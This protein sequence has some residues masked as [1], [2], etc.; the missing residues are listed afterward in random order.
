MITVREQVSPLNGA[1]VFGRRAFRA[2]IS[3]VERRDASD[4]AVLTVIGAILLLLPAIW[5]GHPFLFPDSEHYFSIGKSIV[6]SIAGKIAGALMAGGA[7]S[8]SGGEPVAAQAGSGGLA[9]I[10]GG[11]SPVYAVL[12]YGLAVRAGIWGIVILQSA[13]VSWLTVMVLNLV[14]G[15]RRAGAVVAALAGLALVTPAGAFSGFLMPDV[16]AAT[17]VLAAVLLVFDATA[18]RGRSLVYAS[19]IALSLVMHATII[20]LG[21][22]AFALVALCLPIPAARRLVR[23]ESLLWLAGALVLSIAFNAAYVR[24]A[25]RLS[26]H[27]IS[28]PPYLMAR[29]IAD[30]PGQK[31]LAATC[32]TPAAPFAACAFAHQSFVDHNDFLWGNAS[33]G[34]NFSASPQDLKTALIAEEGR[35]VRD[36]VARYPVEQLIASTHNALRQFVRVGMEEFSIGTHL[37]VDDD[38]FRHAAILKT[39]PSLEGCLDRPGSC[40]DEGALLPTLRLAYGV[41]LLSCFGALAVTM[42]YW[43]VRPRLRNAARARLDRPMLIGTGLCLLLLINAAACGALSGPH[44]RYQTRLVWLAPL[45]LIALAVHARGLWGQRLTR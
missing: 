38:A 24:L 36:A 1:L 11:R 21:A 45:F 22:C 42:L 25:E 31:L 29:V 32:T 6:G 5:N 16:F 27:T 2:S 44:D 39:I 26:G 14:W 34:P 17:F 8:A 20:L 35:F 15:V 3:A 40:P 30:G 12:L 7:G 4:I 41:N 9:A 43:T 10:A 28:A 19:V 37:L 33:H 13:L 23:A 18:S